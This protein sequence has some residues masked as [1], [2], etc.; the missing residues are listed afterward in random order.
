MGLIGNVHSTI[1]AMEDQNANRLRDD[2]VTFS[3]APV[4]AS[5]KLE[6]IIY[7]GNGR[8]TLEKAPHLR[9]WEVSFPCCGKWN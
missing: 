1:A 5:T 3:S 8:L 6:E 2:I 4:S 9:S 7:H